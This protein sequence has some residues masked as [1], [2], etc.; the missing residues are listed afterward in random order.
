MNWQKKSTYVL[1]LSVGTWFR[2]AATAA[3][4]PAIACYRRNAFAM[5]LNLPE[6]ALGEALARVPL[7][8]HDTLATTCKR[9]RKI[10]KSDS[11]GALRRRLGWTE[12]GVFVLGA[13][14]DMIDSECPDSD[15]TFFCLTHKSD[16]A[17]PPRLFT[18][19]CNVHISMASCEERGLLVVSGD[20]TG[21]AEDLSD[22]D[23]LVYDMR[24]RSWL[25]VGSPARTMPAHL[26]V[27]MYDPCLAFVN[28]QLVVAGSQRKMRWSCLV[29]TGF[30]AVWK[31]PP[32]RFIKRPP[33]RRARLYVI[34]G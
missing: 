12:A 11:F 24:S 4:L 3:T 7:E 26:P 14:Q 6:D 9:L 8:A 10:V 25:P 15:D 20:H 28:G 1:D 16:V 33:G 22:Y 34:G 13:I 19:A 21:T 30:A 5:L 27:M 31:P 32:M 23:L 2:I 18:D 17:Q 29:G